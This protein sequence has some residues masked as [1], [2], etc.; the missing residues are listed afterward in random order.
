MLNAGRNHAW[1]IVGALAILLGGSHGLITGGIS[2]FDSA[3]LDDLGIT[4]GALKFRDLLQ[5]FTAGAWALLIGFVTDRL[6]PR[7][8]IYVGLA[9]L[10]G[11][12]FAY[13]LVHDVTQIYILHMLLAFSYSSCHVVVVVVIITRWFANR[14]G[15][16][17]GLIL[18]GESL[19]GTIFPQVV[20]WLINEFGWRGAMQWLALM[21]AGFAL[22]ML[23]TLRGSPESL[24]H[25]KVGQED[26]SDSGETTGMDDQDRTPKDISQEE[27]PPRSVLSYVTQPYALTVYIVAATS[28][29]TGAAFIAHAFLNF[30]DR[31]FSATLA[32]SS[33]SL[34]FITAFVGKLSSGF[35]AERWGSALVWCVFIGML[36]SGTA[37]LTFGSSYLVWIAVVVFGLGWG[38]CYT[39]TQ[40]IIAERFAGPHLARLAGIAVM[41]EGLASGVGSWVTGVLFDQTGSYLVPSIV[42]CSMAFIALLFALR[43][44]AMTE[45]VRSRKVR[46]A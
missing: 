25:K 19:G 33:V 26:E 44:W 2:I 34:I 16:A 10:S 37:M 3:I 39:V 31:G 14:K 30:Q 46:N 20:I 18:A 1:V 38:G 22:L 11:V 45:R 42:M 40:A 43:M 21:P 32:A 29:Y 9:V 4:R 13:S 28:F 36:F 35:V 23:A 7:T 15:I 27:T 5:L 41:I 8:I 6:G 24:G 12:L 17:L